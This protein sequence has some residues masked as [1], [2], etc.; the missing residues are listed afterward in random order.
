M[1]STRINFF[2][3]IIIWHL[4]SN[5]PHLLPS[6]QVSARTISSTL[7]S[8][9]A[10]Y[11]LAMLPTPPMHKSHRKHSSSLLDQLDPKKIYNEGNI[12]RTVLCIAQ[13]QHV[14]IYYIY[15]SHKHMDTHTHTYILKHTHSLTHNFGNWGWAVL[16]HMQVLTVFPKYS[17]HF[18]IKSVGQWGTGPSTLTVT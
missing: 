10:S 1:L 3:L 8:H 5:N 4:L 15:I 11:V 16:S 7:Q 9:H 18:H 12:W 13:S 14:H 17:T 2:I 6:T